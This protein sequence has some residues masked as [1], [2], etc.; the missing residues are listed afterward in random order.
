MLTR[1]Q[2]DHLC[3]LTALNLSD[4]QKE[5]MLPEIASILEIID[6]LD[7][8]VLDSDPGEDTWIFADLPI[9]LS[10]ELLRRDE[11]IA[12]IRHHIVHSMP[13]LKTGLLK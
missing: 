8:C 12:N 9:G 6:Q 4:E 11:F 10:E 2:L 13:E 5:V 1:E 3:M 7:A